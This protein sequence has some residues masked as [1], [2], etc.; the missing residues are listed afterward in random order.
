MPSTTLSDDSADDRALP[1]DLQRLAETL[2]HPFADPRIL[3]QAFRHRSWC[4]EHD[5]PS[6]ERLEFLGDSVL[7]LVVTDH[8]YTSYPE[9][10]E[11]ALAKMRAAVVSS[12]S[13]ASLAEELELGR[14]L[15][16]GRGEEATGGR[17]KSSILADALEAVIGAVF[18]DGG[19]DA[20]R[21]VVLSLVQDRIERAALGPG[22]QDYKTR[23]QE[24]V[25]R[26]ADGPLR[27][28]MTEDGP[29][30]DK[31]F[32]AAVVVGGDA[33]GTGAGKSKKQAQ[34]A[35]AQDAWERLVSETGERTNADAR[36]T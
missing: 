22:V 23:L 26:R 15:Q 28:A 27:Y 13:L 31:R 1:E 35:A 3:D 8:A 2:G 19:W 32:V 25:A 16:L 29:D 33:L 34:Q 21:R 7:G 6:N 4:A 30:H 36:A 17:H 10:P 5:G 9:L 12:A 20:A 11:G 18:V 24:L 14:H